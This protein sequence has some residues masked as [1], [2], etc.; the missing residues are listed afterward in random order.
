MNQIIY[1]KPLTL[2]EARAVYNAHA[3]HDFPDNELKPFSLIEKLWN[4]GCYK[5]CGFYEKG[6]GLLCAYAFT[7]ADQDTNMLLLDYFAVCKE[8]REKGYG[9]MAISLLKQD[10][11]M[12]DGMIFEVEDDDTA[13]AEE[14]RHIRKRRIAFY[15]KNGVVMTKGRSEAFGVDYKLMVMALGSEAAGDRLEEKITSVY[16]KMLP[17]K[18]FAES[19]RIRNES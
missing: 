12:W 19:F 5:G 2:E 14:E 4:N 9:S 1:S 16:K 15:E 10:Y 11:T 18:V 8:M 17:Q 7:M 3:Q 13:I 6:T